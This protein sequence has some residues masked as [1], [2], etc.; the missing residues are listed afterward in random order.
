[1][2]TLAGQE[3]TLPGQYLEVLDLF[4]FHSGSIELHLMGHA[5]GVYCLVGALGMTFAGWGETSH[6][7]SCYA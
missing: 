7:G 4:F 3:I 2:L 6:C 1:M 5:W